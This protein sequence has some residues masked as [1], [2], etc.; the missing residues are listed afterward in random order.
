MKSDLQTDLIEQAERKSRNVFGIVVDKTNKPLASA[1]IEAL[2]TSGT[3]IT[4]TT[5][6]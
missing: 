5:H 3:I 4:S 6:L 1:K 2:D